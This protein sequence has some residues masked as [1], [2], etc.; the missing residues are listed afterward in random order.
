M[1][2]ERAVVVCVELDRRYAP[3]GAIWPLADEAQELHEL[4]R[5]SGCQ[6]VGE[7]VARRHRPIAGTLLGAGKLDELASVVT[8]A[9]AQLAVFNCELSPAQRARYL[10]ALRARLHRSI[11][12]S[13]Y[14][15]ILVKEEG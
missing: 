3:G 15:D 11:Q 6:V 12:K 14:G 7:L 2:T 1:P 4:A 10:A 8:E 5:S 9:Q 13:G